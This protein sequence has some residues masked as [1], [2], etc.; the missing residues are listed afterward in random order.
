MG[1]I[2]RLPGVET[3]IFPVPVYYENKTWRIVSS[4]IWT[5]LVLLGMIALLALGNLMCPE[6]FLSLRNLQNI[7]INALNIGLL[8]LMMTVIFRNGG[9][10][11]SV[12]AVIAVTGTIIAF[13]LEHGQQL[14][15]AIIL[16][17]GAALLIGLINGILVGMARLPGFL[18][19]L[20]MMFLGRSIALLLLNGNTMPIN[21]ESWPEN[22]EMLLNI[23]SWSLLILVGVVAVLWAQLPVGGGKNLN[24]QDGSPSWI[25]RAC[26]LGAPYLI[27]S[28]LA[29]VVGLLLLVRI[30][31]ATFAMGTYFEFDVILA[32]VIGGTYFGSKFGNVIGTLCGAFWLAALTNLFNLLNLNI[33]YLYLCKGLLLLIGLLI[34]F[35]YHA[36]V[37]FF[38][39]QKYGGQTGDAQ[40]EAERER[41]PQLKVAKPAEPVLGNR[42]FSGIAPDTINAV[43][44]SGRLFLYIPI[45]RLILLYIVSGGTYGAYWIYKNWQYVKQRD[46]LKIN[47]FW[48]GVFGFFFCYSLFKRIQADPEARSIEEPRFSAGGLA[49]GFIVLAILSNLIIR[50]PGPIASIFGLLIPSYLFLLPVQNYLNSVNRKKEPTQPYYQWS[51]GHIVCLVF[52]LIVW[53]LVFIVK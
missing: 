38:Y 4:F 17:I 8:A 13:A 14:D 32:V 7:A 10:D 30:R 37:G 12:G 51:A 44:S 5:G 22:S 3:E 53:V 49:T 29:G 33:P 1:K 24:R 25:S 52:G 28:I 45:S 19:T 48:R 9:A 21:I 40:S 23:F 31:A 50:I 35:G 15:K 42:A 11:L 27:L 2:L 36:L 41:T 18:V 46:G 6:A 47:P 43:P 26:A 16:G 20:A 39:R 34:I